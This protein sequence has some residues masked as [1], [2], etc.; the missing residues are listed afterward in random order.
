MKKI[1][2]PILCLSFLWL[3]FPSVSNASI[4]PSNLLQSA[5]YNSDYSSNLFNWK[6]DENTSTYYV[7]DSQSAYYCSLWNSLFKIKYNSSLWTYYICDWNEGYCDI[8]GWLFTIKDGYICP[9]WVSTCWVWSSLW[10]PPALIPIES[11]ITIIDWATASITQYMSKMNLSNWVYYICSSNTSVCWNGSEFMQVK[12]DSSNSTYYICDSNTS[13]CSN[14]SDFM[15]IKYDSFDDS[16]YVCDW[17]TVAC[18]IS[19]D[20]M[21][22]KYDSSNST[23][24]ICDSNT[25]ACSTISDYIQVKKDDNNYY[26]CNWN[27]VSCYVW[28]SIYQTIAEWSSKQVN[29]KN[30]SNWN[31]IIVSEESWNMLN[32]KY[33]NARNLIEKWDYDWAIE[34]L[35]E[36]LGYEWKIIWWDNY[37]LARKVLDIAEN[38]KNNSEKKKS[39]SINSSSNNIEHKEY[40]NKF[41][42]MEDAIKWM[43]DNWL[44][45]YDNWS[46]FMA[47]DP[48]TREQASK[49]FVEFA[50]KVLWKDRW[51]VS[52]YDI[53]TDIKNANPTLKN[54]II[55]S[56]NMWM[57]KW[58]NWKFMP[59]NNLTIAQSLA[60]LIRLVDWQL[61]ESW[62]KPYYDF[63]FWE[64]YWWYFQYLSHA[65]FYKI[66]KWWITDNIDWLDSEN[67][68]RW[69]LAI[70]LYE[71]AMYLSNPNNTRLGNN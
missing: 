33:D 23:Y 39:N 62:T 11:L 70:L 37:D 10:V 15:Q 58:N 41:S 40:N 46:T 56:Y 5:L 24:Y 61:D 29:N 2:L 30:N 28:S 26:T 53:F 52:S 66:N 42:E 13:T 17:D 50:V 22:I 12:Y 34:L 36:I 6:Y 35:N 45:I 44:T 54:H 71:M 63:N 27:T 38:A 49:F 31:S 4:L 21:Q 64:H 32:E 20:F 14:V 3:L 18:S 60:V 51:T 48:I 1:W 59:F 67:I 68:T 55:Y 8:A 25:S 65:G 47:Y 57:F 16:Y 19:S 9:W 7:C 69:N 43:Y